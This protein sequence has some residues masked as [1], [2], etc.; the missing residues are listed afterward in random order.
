M[1]RVACF[2]GQ[3]TLGDAGE[4]QQVADPASPVRSL[5]AGQ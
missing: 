1:I 4:S 5:T 2:L 3:A